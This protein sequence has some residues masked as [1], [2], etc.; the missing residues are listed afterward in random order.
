MFFNFNVVI[1]V[2]VKDSKFV[3]ALKTIGFGLF[4]NSSYDLLHGDFTL[5]GVYIG[6][7]GLYAIMV[8]Y[9]AEKRSKNG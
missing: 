4:I 6:L 5:S 7:G 9:Y 1:I 2:I 3:E 8:S